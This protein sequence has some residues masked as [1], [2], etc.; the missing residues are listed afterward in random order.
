VI[1]AIAGCILWFG[2]R[3]LAWSIPGTLAFLLFAAMVLPCLI[4]ARATAQR[5]A[6]INNLRRIDGAKEVL[7]KERSLGNEFIPTFSDLV[8]TN[9]TREL[10][11]IPLE[12]PGGGTYS[13]GRIDTLP[14]CSLSEK[15]HRLD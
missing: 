2:R 8:N 13:I 11:K 1:L 10:P 14:V 15:G 4:P 7:A 5:N 12:C 3:H 9:H 6:C